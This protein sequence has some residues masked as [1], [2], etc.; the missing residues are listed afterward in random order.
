[1]LPTLPRYVLRE[2]ARLY[3]VGLALF[4]ILQMTDVLSTTVGKAMQSHAS[5]GQF[6]TALLAIM[7]DKLN[8][9]LVMSVPFAMLLGLSRLQ[10]DSEIKAILAAGIR[11]LSVIWP[12]LLPALLIGGVTFYNTSTLVPAGQARWER[13]WYGIYGQLPPI[14]SQDKYTYAPQGALYYAGRVTPDAAGQT[15]Q[16]SGV[17]VRRGDDTLTALVGQWNPANKTWTLTDPWVTRPGQVPTQTLGQLSVPQNDTLQPPPPDPRKVSTVQL[18][19]E[20][21]GT[22]LTPESRRNY[23]YQLASRYADPFT[24]IAFALAAGG[25]GLL[26]RSR[27]AATG[28]VVVFIAS[29]YVLWI[30]MQSL[31]PAG[32][33]DPVFAAWLPS[34]VFLVLGLVLAWRLR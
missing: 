5:F 7:P 28:A 34:L 3:A 8:R 14:P 19:H 26:F 20:L 32:A 33:L 23:Q 15:A 27:I 30:T 18:R 2:I 1:M 11:P 9:A 6:M 13:T 10:K 16:L 24:P 22:A 4:L 17:M 25:L 29:F 31:A 12:L 21:A